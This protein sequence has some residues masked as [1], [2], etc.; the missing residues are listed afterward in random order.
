[1]RSWKTDDLLDV[2]VRTM[3]STLRE[4]SI[5]LIARKDV[6]NREQLDLMV[7]SYVKWT[8]DGLYKREILN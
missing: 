3:F 4:F 5:H 6:M 2:A 7:D 1:M 8:T